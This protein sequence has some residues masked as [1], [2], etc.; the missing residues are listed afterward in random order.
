MKLNTILKILALSVIFTLL[1]CSSTKGN[2]TGNSSQETMPEG[3]TKM[4]LGKNTLY[5]LKDHTGERLQHNARFY[6]ENDQR[7]VDKLSP[8]GVIA[9]SIH[10]FLLKREGKSILFDTGLG[11]NGRLWEHLKSLNI[12]PTEIDY[13]F[14]THMHGDHIGGMLKNREKTF[15]NATI[16]VSE[17]EYNYWIQNTDSQAYKVLKLYE[18]QLKKFQYSDKLPLGIIPIEAHGH[19]PGHTAFEVDNLLIVG[20]IL[21]GA[22]LQLQ[23]LSLCASYDMDKEKSISSRKKVIDY[24][25]KNKKTMAGMHLPNNGILDYTLLP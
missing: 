16:L 8:N 18:N 9:S 23:D 4:V 15:Q 3:V 25:K 20:D 24:A 1:H 19:T 11:E 21:H 14:L 17:T 5:T 22:E 2:S 10:S 12:R 7:K 13:I 6:G